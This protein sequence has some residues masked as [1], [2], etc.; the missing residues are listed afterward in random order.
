MATCYYTLISI[1]LQRLLY[2]N[3][4]SIFSIQQIRV[5]STYLVAN[6]ECQI[7]LTMKIFCIL[8]HILLMV[9]LYPSFRI[10]VAHLDSKLRVGILFIA[11]TAHVIMRHEYMRNYVGM[12][13]RMFKYISCSAGCK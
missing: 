1:I 5:Q 7:Y 4:Q 6:V 2:S 9:A 10:P 3:G 11:K 8:V 13:T 12:S